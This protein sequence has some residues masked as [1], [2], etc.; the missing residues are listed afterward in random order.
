MY[1]LFRCENPSVFEVDTNDLGIVVDSVDEACAALCKQ[2][3][4]Q[5]NFANWE[6]T[7]FADCETLNDVLKLV[8]LYLTVINLIEGNDIEVYHDDDDK[9]DWYEVFIPLM[10]ELDIPMTI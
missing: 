9:N 6:H 1:V 10:K 2:I 4:A 5:I 3:R 7:E 8:R